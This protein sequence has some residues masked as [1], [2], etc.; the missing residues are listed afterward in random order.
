MSGDEGPLPSSCSSTY[1][2]FDAFLSFKQEDT[3]D[4]LAGLLYEALVDRG[5]LTVF[6]EED[7]KKEEN[8]NRLLTCIEVS[9]VFVPIFSI[10]YAQSRW[11]LQEIA[12]MVECRRCIVPV[13]LGVDPS[14][15]RYQTGTYGSYFAHHEVYESEEEVEKWRQALNEAGS[16]PGFHFSKEIDRQEKK[17]IPLVVK[18]V[19]K[20]LKKTFS[21][22]AEHPIGIESRVE[23][24]MQLLNLGDEGLLVVGIQGIGGIG[25]TTIAKAI[26]N[27][28]Y[29]RFEA[30]SFI[31]DIREKSRLPGGLAAMQRKLH[32]DISKDSISAGTAE[33]GTLTERVLVI[34]DDV[35]HTDQIH[36]L[37]GE[38]VQFGPG[39]RIIITTRYEEVLVMSGV[40]EDQIYKPKVLDSA[41]SL[42]LFCY[43]AFVSDQP[44]QE[45]AELSGKVVEVTGGLPLELEVFGALF[46]DIKSKEE[47]EEML[48]KLQEVRHEENVH[49]LRMSYERLDENEK[50]IFLDIACFFI[51]RGKEYAMHMW[52]DCGL[53]PHSAI[54]VLIHKSLVRID[55]QKDEFAMHDQ[56]RDMG[57]E[58]VLSEGICQSRFWDVDRVSKAL[59]NHDE[60]GQHI[61]GIVLNLEEGSSTYLSAKAFEALSNLRMLRANFVNFEDC[62][63]H[64]L[65]EKL[66]WL[67]WRGCPLESLPLNCKFKKLSVL[68]LSQSNIS[69]LWKE[70]SGPPQTEPDIYL[71][72]KKGVFNGLKVLDLSSCSYLSSSPGLASVPNLQKLILDYCSNLTE[73]DESIGCLKNLTFLSMRMCENLN[74]L[75]KSMHHLVSLKILNLR[76]CSKLFALPEQFP[77][78]LVTLDAKDCTALKITPNFSNLTNL[79]TLNLQG[80]KNII[81]F[82]GLGDLKSIKCLLMDGCEGFSCGFLESFKGK[83]F[84]HLELLSTTASLTFFESTEHFIFLLPCR[85][86]NDPLLVDSVHCHGHA[87]RREGQ[88]SCNSILISM[89]F[90][91]DNELVFVTKKE[92][93]RDTNNDLG[94]QHRGY[95]YSV[96]V[97][98]FDET[99]PYVAAQCDMIS[100]STSDGSLLT[101]VDIKLRHRDYWTKAES[102]VQEGG[103][104]SETSSP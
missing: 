16:Y 42:Q 11:C 50:C 59:Q 23:D 51:G 71:N 76:Y 7:A 33:T 18:K 24:V 14:E 9:K 68:I 96:N 97:N 98:G 46:Y 40:H 19:L 95:C 47:W 39:S 64:Q 63:F 78:S 54:E 35:D 52:E 81:G 45:F 70:Q 57:R 2:E 1:L 60:T 84:K 80:C 36:S 86:N 75:P 62:D 85:S 28:L 15:V 12:K 101:R 99:V 61:E 58:V 87:V 22:V 104:P 74:K 29:D 13:F 93:Y 103:I 38:K 37:M 82:R 6:D 21:N 89:K 102:H 94:D 79:E 4:L 49:K 26:S 53:F 20:K 48:K 66:K 56:I 25:K 83:R 44:P 73:V 31:F 8:I 92:A 17:V 90:H 55:D 27:E 5:V 41:Q 100:V 72:Q 10:N 69:Q 77:S 32:E 43:Y 91:D 30:R 3:G 67:E 34:L 88:Q 65:P